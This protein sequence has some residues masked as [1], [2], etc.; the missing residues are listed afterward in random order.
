MPFKLALEQRLAQVSV[1]SPHELPDVS[2]RA[3]K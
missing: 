1:L 2:M 3:K